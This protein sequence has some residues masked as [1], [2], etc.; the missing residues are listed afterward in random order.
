MRV[1][2]SFQLQALRYSDYVR[3]NVP[4]KKVK[5]VQFHG[6]LRPLFIH[7]YML[8]NVYLFAKF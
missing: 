4:F 1:S 5:L 3:Y 8:Q 2:P 7:Y 6:M